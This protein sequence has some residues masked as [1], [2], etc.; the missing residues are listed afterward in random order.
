MENNSITRIFMIFIKY[1]LNI[2][3]C[4]G[5]YSENMLQS[6]LNKMFPSMEIVNTTGSK[7]SGDFICKLGRNQKVFERCQ[8]TKM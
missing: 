4:K 5:Q 2:S 7:A 3:T 6:I 8:R 1:S